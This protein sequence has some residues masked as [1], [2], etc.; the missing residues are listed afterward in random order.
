[1]T[2]RSQSHSRGISLIECVLYIALFFIVATLTFASYYRVDGETRALNRNA[3]DI[4]HA[5]KAGERWRAD[6]RQATERPRVENDTLKFTTKTG[7]VTY[8]V[9]DRTLWRQVGQTK[10]LPILER[11]KFSSMQPDTRQQVTAWRWELELETKRAEASV[12][13]LFT[14]TAVPGNEVER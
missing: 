7:D 13:P 4:S 6:L 8:A 1:M 9:R 12:R 2:I 5:M 11:V 14:F 3:E 10:A